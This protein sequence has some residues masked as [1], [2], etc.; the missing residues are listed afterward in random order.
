MS[1]TDIDRCWRAACELQIFRLEEAAERAGVNPD[2]CAEYLGAFVDLGLLARAG[3]FYHSTRRRD[4]AAAYAEQLRSKGRYRLRLRRLAG[5]AVDETDIDR[6]WRVAEARQLVRLDEAGEAASSENLGNFVR[7]VELD[8]LARNDDLYRSEGDTDRRLKMI[9]ATCLWDE[10]Q[11]IV[12]D[13][14]V[15]EISR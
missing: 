5:G 9:V 2:R 13:I 1:D 10:A 11:G 8:L 15:E 14:D 7:L 4:R 12:G 6:C 3:D